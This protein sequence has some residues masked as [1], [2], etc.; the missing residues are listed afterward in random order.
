MLLALCVIVSVLVGTPLG[1]LAM[2]LNSLSSCAT[3]TQ[4][5]VRQKTS[6][7]KESL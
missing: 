7:R 5:G 6:T 4:T 2:P 3:V 1:L